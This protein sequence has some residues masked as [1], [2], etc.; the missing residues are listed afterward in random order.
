M[1]AVGREG[2]GEGW[3]VWSVCK[4]PW[5]RYLPYRYCEDVLNSNGNSGAQQE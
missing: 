2:G 5:Y 4:E 1:T 3:G